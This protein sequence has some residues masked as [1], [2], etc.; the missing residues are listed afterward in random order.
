MLAFLMLQF[1]TN[2]SWSSLGN[3]IFPQ[4]NCLFVLKIRKH[5][6]RVSHQLE[7]WLEAVVIQEVNEGIEEGEVVHWR[8]E[9]LH[10][11]KGKRQSFNF[12]GLIDLSTNPPFCPGLRD[13]RIARLNTYYNMKAISLHYIITDQL[14][15]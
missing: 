2:I 11:A 8:M 12:C 5:G 1:F 4:D 15:K 13:L 10:T 9:R 6:G 3:E 14:S 7:A